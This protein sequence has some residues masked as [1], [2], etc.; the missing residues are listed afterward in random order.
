V[1][2]GGEGVSPRAEGTIITTT[3]FHQGLGAHNT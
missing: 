1:V 3:V 2:G